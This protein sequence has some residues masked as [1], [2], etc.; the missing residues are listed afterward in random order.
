M[1]VHTVTLSILPLFVEGE[2]KMPS[3]SAERA[4]WPSPVKRGLREGTKSRNLQ[5]LS[6][7]DHPSQIY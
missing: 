2:T 4:A 5:W 1:A 3:V 7:V 6:Q